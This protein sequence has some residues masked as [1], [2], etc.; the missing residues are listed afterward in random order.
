[1]T[2]P[3][4]TEDCDHLAT[5]GPYC[6]RCT[7]QRQANRNRRRTH[8]IT[9]ASAGRTETGGG[10]VRISVALATPP[11][12]RP[13]P[14]HLGSSDGRFWPFPFFSLWGCPGPRRRCLDAGSPGCAT[15]TTSGSRCD[16]CRRRRKS[17][18]NAD[19]TVAAQ[20]VAAWRA[21]HGDWCPGW[22][23]PGHPA[24]DLTAEHGPNPV[25]SRRVQTILCRSCNSRKGRSV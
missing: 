4:L 6:T 20:A 2:R 11:E 12:T 24:A 25:G 9:Q 16:T 18:R 14:C 17:A 7:A 5:T 1:M 13:L 8:L 15:Y 10:A 19:R 23:R 3:C 21:V 22:R